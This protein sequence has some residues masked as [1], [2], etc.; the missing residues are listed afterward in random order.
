MKQ[1]MFSS[2][3]EG[4]R[5]DIE[6]AFGMLQARFHIITRPCKLW[7]RDAMY[8][9]MKTCVIIHNLILDYEKQQGLDSLYIEDQHFET[10]QPFTISAR[11]SANIFDANLSATELSRIQDASMH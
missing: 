7:Y 6:R 9:V 3:Q 8:S 11:R 1:K 10:N 5:K 2:K 4:K